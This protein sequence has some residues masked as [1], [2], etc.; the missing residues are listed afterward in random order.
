MNPCIDN[1]N[2]N[3]TKELFMNH[4]FEESQ[5]NL[6]CQ[7]SFS[8]PVMG[9]ECLFSFAQGDEQPAAST[10]RDLNLDGNKFSAKFA[11]LPELSGNFNS[12]EVQH[13]AMIDCL[14]NE[15]QIDDDEC[16]QENCTHYLAT[17]DSTSSDH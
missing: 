10:S 6:N 5:M 1:N 7:K 14:S 8:Y 2:N 11:N 12:I 13:D 3:C 15:V 16:S 4:Q 9:D 17:H